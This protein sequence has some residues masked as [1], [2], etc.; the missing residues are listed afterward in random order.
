MSPINLLQPPNG[1]E[2]LMSRTGKRL[3]EHWWL[4]RLIYTERRRSVPDT[5]VKVVAVN[6]AKCLSLILALVSEK[7]VGSTIYCRIH[8]NHFCACEHFCACGFKSSVILAA[9]VL[10]AC[11][12]QLPHALL[13]CRPIMSIGIMCDCC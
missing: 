11:A 1:V 12:R 7:S 5:K 13:H 8:C 9:F 10:H 2:R 4:Y 6:V 3:R